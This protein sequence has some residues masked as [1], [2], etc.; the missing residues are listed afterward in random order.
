MTGQNS[1]T[2]TALACMRGERPVFS[3]LDFAI[4]SGGALVLIGANGSGKSSLLRLMAGLLPPTAGTLTWNGLSI[5]EEPELH[6]QRTAYLG[7][8]GAIKPLLTPAEDVAFWV[9]YRAPRLSRAEVTLRVQESLAWA[10]LSGLLDMPSR[11]LSA[12][13]RQRLALARLT[14]HPTARLWLLDEPTTS[15]DAAGI[16]ALSTCLAAH[17]ARG[18]MVIAATH[19]KLD[20]PQAQE[21]DLGI[22]ARRRVEAG[23]RS[24]LLDA[25]A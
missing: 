17:R 23:L 9:R 8:L 22:F 12:G 6:R 18:G 3:G 14:A 11:F 13:Q 1:F 21:L 7:H 15:L 25:V 10:G 5:T 24:A 19:Q 2:G 16:V 20:L 4:G